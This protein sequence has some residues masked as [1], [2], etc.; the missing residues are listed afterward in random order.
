MAT[1]PQIHSVYRS[2]NKPLIILGVERRLF[3]LALLM[4]SAT[5]NYFGSLIGGLLMFAVLF[6]LARWSTASDPQMLRILLNSAKFKARYDP[7]NHNV[8][9][10]RRIFT[11][12]K[13]GARS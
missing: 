9:N 12:E 13:L 8:F 4:G 1:I 3:F 10:L 6:V 7:A 2:I 5:F 11:H